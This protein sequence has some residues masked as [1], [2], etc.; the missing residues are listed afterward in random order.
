DPGGTGF[1]FAD[2]LL[3][4]HDLYRTAA[5]GALYPI[6]DQVVLAACSSLGLYG[7]PWAGPVDAPEWLGLGAAMVYG[8]ARHVFCTLYDVPTRATPAGSIAHWSTRCGSGSILPGPSGRSSVLSSIA[9]STAA[10]R[11]RWS[12][13]PTPT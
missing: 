9:G 11:C 3:G 5:G 4:L 12:S 6:P 7:D 1:E 8:G 13:S 2:G 10:A